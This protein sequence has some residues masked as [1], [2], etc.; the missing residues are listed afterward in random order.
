MIIVG[1]DPGVHGAMCI[2]NTY[3]FRNI[4]VYPFS[5]LTLADAY[6][7]LSEIRG[8]GVYKTA[9]ANHVLS[10]DPSV[11]ND[12]SPEESDDNTMEIWLEEPGQIV[13]NRLTKGKDSTGALLAGMTASRKLG[14][15]I[16]QW[17]GIGAALNVKVE[18]VPPRKWQSALGCKAKGDKKVLKNCAETIVPSLTKYNASGRM[19]EITLDTADAVLIAV[20]GYMQYASKEYWPVALKNYIKQANL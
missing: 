19:E 14:R 15:S 4:R 9:R 3:K 7:F 8:G 18:L 17:E 16:G 1:I 6:L 20:Y 2:I 12:I 13:V 5:R 11:K 10:S